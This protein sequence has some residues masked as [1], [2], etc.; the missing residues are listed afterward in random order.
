[1]FSVT[2]RTRLRS[3]MALVLLCAAFF[4][5]VLDST[6]IF[7]ALPSIGEDLGANSTQLAWVV[8][9]YGIIVAGFML[10]FGRVA[11]I[12]GRRTVFIAAVTVFGLGS[13][14]CSL[15]GSGAAL[16]IARAAQG[17]GAAA[18]TPA[19]L[20][21]L[22]SMYPEGSRRNRALGIW[23][24]LGGVGATAGL[25]LGGVITDS[26]GWPWIF[27][28]NI[29]VCLIIALI[30]PRLLPSERQRE[31]RRFDLLGGVLLSATL[32]TTVWAL[33]EI[34]TS[35]WAPQTW[36][37]LGAAALLAGVV[38]VVE[39]RSTDPIFPAR[40]FRSRYLVIGNIVIV[41]SGIGVDGLLVLTTIYT[42]QVL[43]LSSMLFGITLAAM[44]VSSVFAVALGQRFVTRCGL[45]PVATAGLGMLALVC[46]LFVVLPDDDK[47]I[48]FFVGGLVVFGMGIGT[49]FVAG[50][51]AA[52]T[53]IHPDDAGTAAG[54]EETTF[55][56]GGTLGVAIVTATS[57]TVAGLA[58]PDAS[59]AGALIG[60]V[61]ASFIAL[62]LI[63]AA[64]TVTALA[65][66]KKER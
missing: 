13:L 19:A 39:R 48:S 7:A 37:P 14:A 29:P 35:G 22:L 31:R 20:A 49:A 11:D 50:Q 38:V 18:L 57:M 10:P 59:Q 23:G 36:L 62:S 63:A 17:L 43:G 64:G 46:A 41:T 27:S 40:L 45:R 51:I 58:A 8:T 30:A 12:L 9:V 65:L 53:G 47:G 16:I 21:L 52:V 3:P 6:S 32:M 24:G 44:T 28:I 25:L 66:P 56:I 15:S 2:L 4:M 61:R 33:L 1:M 5:T 54:L 34:P 60:G 26:I 55:A 42:Q